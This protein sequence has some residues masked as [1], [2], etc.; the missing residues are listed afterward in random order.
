MDGK[1]LRQI[2]TR[3]KTWDRGKGKTGELFIDL[4]SDDATFR[5]I[6]GG[7][8]AM[9]FT[10][11]HS[12]REKIRAYFEGLMLDWQ[13]IFYN[14]RMFLVV[15]DTVAVICECAWKHR[16][17]GK[18]VHSPKLD[19]IRVK[20]GKMQDFFEFFDTHQAYAACVPDGSPDT[21]RP[22]PL[23][24]WGAARTVTEATEA[25]TA[26]VK[27]LRK[28]YARWHETKGSSGSARAFVNILAANVI[29]GS[30]GAGTRPLAFT[31]TRM[32]RDEVGQYFRE[33]GSAYEMNFYYV[34]EYIAAGPFVLVLADVSFTSRKTGKAFVSPKA[35]LWRFARGKATEFYEYYDTA[36]AV[37]AAG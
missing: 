17:T 8:E 24:K 4:L 13:M 31:Q 28:L 25:T 10:R 36:K 33:L 5:S 20:N 2:K 32:T 7:V 1:I 12:T 21:R 26:N 14:V 18:I 23:Y 16:H 11:T 6:G 3:Y 27:T 15:G 29:W 19:I 35:D 34:K 30:L 9:Q 22:K 37:T